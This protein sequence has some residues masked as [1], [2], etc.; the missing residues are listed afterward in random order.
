MI[1]ST[2]RQC[3]HTSKRMHFIEEGSGSSGPRRF[4][5]LHT[6]KR[7]HF[8]EEGRAPLH[9]GTRKIL[10]TSKRM[11]FIEELIR[12]GAVAKR[13]TCIRQNV[14]TSLRI[15]RIRP[16]RSRAVT[17]IRQNVCTSLRK[18]EGGGSQ[19]ASERLAYVKTYALH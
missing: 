13:K 17:C 9:A 19:A 4:G 18:T 10:H 3:L 12:G 2:P 8:I 7:M 1:L 15:D 5:S 11:H 14:C 6:S 16:E